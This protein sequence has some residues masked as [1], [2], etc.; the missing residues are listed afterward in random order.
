VL[1]YFSRLSGLV[2]MNIN[3]TNVKVDVLVKTV[4]VSWLSKR[5]SKYEMQ[6]K[7]YDFGVL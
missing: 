5:A 4:N 6:K 2:T 1:S 7:F 3:L